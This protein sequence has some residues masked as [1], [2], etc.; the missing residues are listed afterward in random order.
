[1]PSMIMGTMFGDEGDVGRA[2]AR[3]IDRD[4]TAGADVATRSVVHR[5]QAL[6]AGGRRHRR[7]AV[8]ECDRRGRLRQMMRHDFE[9]R[10]LAAFGTVRRPVGGDLAP[11]RAAAGP[12]SRACRTTVARRDP[13]DAD[14]AGAHPP[15]SRSPGGRVR[16]RPEATPAPGMD[17][18]G[19]HAAGH[20]RGR[21]VSRLLHDADAHPPGATSR[22][23]RR[24]RGAQSDLRLRV[25]Q[26]RD[27]ERARTYP[28][29]PSSAH[30]PSRKQRSRRAS[31]S[32]S[33]SAR[34]PCP[35]RCPT[36]SG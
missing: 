30:N 7:I 34:V 4:D 15:A 14:R 21:R 1:M 28:P 25:G 13:T 29:A 18:L 32:N 19:G 16:R 26:R 6:V 2:G 33:W 20:C 9:H 24:G 8:V 31:R 10:L 23:P 5:Q 17:R 36:W 22:R 12:G 35:V 27:A 11:A 3:R